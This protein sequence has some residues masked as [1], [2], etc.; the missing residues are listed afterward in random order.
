MLLQL[1]LDVCL[2]IP[3]HWYCICRWVGR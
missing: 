1:I 2:M 3:F